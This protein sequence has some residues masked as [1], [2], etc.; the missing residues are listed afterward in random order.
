MMEKPVLHKNLPVPGGFVFLEEE[1]PP[2][3]LKLAVIK[4][5]DLVACIPL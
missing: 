2:H 4:W 3:G 5:A 1:H